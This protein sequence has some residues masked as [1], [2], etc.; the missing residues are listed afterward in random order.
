LNDR[1]DP[2]TEIIA[3]RIIEAAQTGLRDPDLIRSAQQSAEQV[4]LGIA[5]I[6]ALWA[7]RKQRSE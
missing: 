2:I 3:R 7:W 6:G 1:D 4:A 5:L